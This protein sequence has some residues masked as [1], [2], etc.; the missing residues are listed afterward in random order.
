MEEF[1]LWGGYTEETTGEEGGGAWEVVADDDG[2]MVRVRWSVP[3]SEGRHLY[4]RHYPGGGW[5]ETAAERQAAEWN[6][7]GRPWIA[8]SAAAEFQ[9][10]APPKV[11]RYRAPWVRTFPAKH[12]HR[13]RL[14]EFPDCWT[15]VIVLKVVRQWGFWSKGRFVPWREYVRS[16]DADQRKACP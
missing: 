12:R 1:G 10:F 15:L 3:D 6:R 5:G 14:E 8:S 7:E 4:V 16:E 9:P 2:Q 11:R 13:L